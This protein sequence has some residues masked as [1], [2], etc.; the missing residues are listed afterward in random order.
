MFSTIRVK[1]FLFTLATTGSV[2]FSQALFVMKF[3]I[4]FL[5]LLGS[6]I[7][8]V[9]KPAKISSFSASTPLGKHSV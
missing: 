5:G 7:N 9:H 3:L 4:T 2:A 1:I 6:D 8:F